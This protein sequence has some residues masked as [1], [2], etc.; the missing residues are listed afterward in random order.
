MADFIPV[1]QSNLIVSA[2]PCSWIR[3][4]LAQPIG[5]GNPCIA[6]SWRWKIA[7]N[8]IRQR[9]DDLLRLFAHHVGARIDLLEHVRD[10]RWMQRDNGLAQRRRISRIERGV[11]LA[12]L[13]TES[14]HDDI[15]LAEQG[16]RAHGVH[17]GADLVPVGSFLLH[18][19][20]DG[21]AVVAVLVARVG[22]RQ[23]DGELFLGD[24]IGDDFAPVRVDL[25]GEVDLPDL[26]R[27]H[28]CGGEVQTGGSGNAC[29][30]GADQRLCGG[31]HHG[32][33]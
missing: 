16:L 31:M 17:V 18:A 32:L 14:H 29:S 28:R 8:D 19:Q 30:C 12:V 26:L 27:C 24:A 5:D 22:R 10:G 25:A 7:V 3:I 21:T 33:E 9:I 15:G 23:R 6:I 20:D 1:S 2:T 13:L 11:P 4:A